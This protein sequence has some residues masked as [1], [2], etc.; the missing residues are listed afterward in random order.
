MEESE[1]ASKRRALRKYKAAIFK[2][3]AH[4]TRIHIVELLKCGE[5]P[6]GTLAERL[7]ISQPCTSQH[8]SI[9]RA[10]HIVDLRREGSQVLY[11]L[12]N[13][14]VGTVLFAMQQYFFEH[15]EQIEGIRELSDLQPPRGRKQL[16]HT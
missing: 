2:A 1:L 16:K 3:M 7:E 14:S 4:P 11:W 9:L 6:V 15:I 8:L 5:L 10:N 13:D 12:K